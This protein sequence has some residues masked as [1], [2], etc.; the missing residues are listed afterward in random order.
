MNAA[1]QI[2]TITDQKASTPALRL[3]EARAELTRLKAAKSLPKRTELWQFMSETFS[4]R[5]PRR[6]KLELEEEVY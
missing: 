2:T 3:E 5:L 6:A 4:I 1:D